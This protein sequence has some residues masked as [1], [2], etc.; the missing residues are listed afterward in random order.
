MSQQIRQS[1]TTIS[2]NAT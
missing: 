2:M 1:V